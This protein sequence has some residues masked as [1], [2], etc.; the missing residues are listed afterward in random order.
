[1]LSDSEP[2]L[3]YIL[4]YW[5]EEWGSKLGRLPLDYTSRS[6]FVSVILLV[7][8]LGTEACLD[9]KGNFI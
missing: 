2:E 8:I 9:P 3:K 5:L 7:T 6:S 4:T 1:M